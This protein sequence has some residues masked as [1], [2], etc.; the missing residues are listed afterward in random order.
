MSFLDIFKKSQDSIEDI[1]KKDETILEDVEDLVDR[2]RKLVLQL[3]DVVKTDRVMDKDATLAEIENKLMLA[4]SKLDSLDNDISMIVQKEM[5]YKDYITIHDDAYLEDKSRKLNSIAS[6]MRELT[7]LV[8]AKP[9]FSELKMDLL[10]RIFSVT[11][12]II[13]DLNQVI[14]DDENLHEIYENMPNM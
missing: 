3:E 13:E 5:K 10:D 8:R 4:T 7:E 6:N 2:L 1:Q 14:E 9:S 11:N 12:Q